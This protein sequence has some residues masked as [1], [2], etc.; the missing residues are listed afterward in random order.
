MLSRGR[1]YRLF[2][3]GVHIHLCELLSSSR[4]CIALRRWGGGHQ[5][6]V[7]VWVVRWRLVARAGFGGLLV[8]VLSSGYHLERNN[9]N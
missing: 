8:V 3:R 7:V 6:R 1:D 2:S 4:V 5:I 9:P